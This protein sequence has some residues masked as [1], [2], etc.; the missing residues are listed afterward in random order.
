MKR[1]LWT[2][3]T[4]GAALVQ[5][6]SAPAKA[7]E[8]ALEFL[9]NVGGFSDSDL[10]RLAKGEVISRVLDTGDKN[11]LA[12]MGA[13]WMNG[14]TSAFVPLYADIEIF[15]R[16]LGPAKK[17]SSPPALS[18]VA[19]LELASSELKALAHCE[20]E[21]CDIHLSEETLAELRGR[22]DWSAPDA[23]R[24]ALA[25]VRE[26][27]VNFARTYLEGGNE[28]LSVYRN[29]SHPRVVSTEFEK[30][31]EKSPY[32]QT[33]VP[34]L[35]RYLLEYP[36]APL[37]GATDFLYWSIIGF[38]PSPTLRLNHVTIYPVEK[39]TNALTVI[40]SKQIYYSRY[41]DT[42]LELYT[43]LPSEARPANGF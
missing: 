27:F 2:G 29:R 24:Q 36:K 15:E 11:E 1:W 7:E 3:F 40:A 31:L 12:L 17:F 37:P 14:T 35:H 4:V 21:D 43:L 34:D 25:F 42:G 38:G 28:A 23:D 6:H 33:Y 16:N 13:A 20:L 19:G 32:V 26:R 30:L 9:K 5:L 10:G 41:F 22:V 18:D 8:G 39:G